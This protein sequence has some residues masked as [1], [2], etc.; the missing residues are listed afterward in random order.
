MEIL[1]L[2]SEVQPWSKTGGLADVA[3]ALP[4]ALA[5]RGH[6]VT[7]VSPLYGGL[8]R[9]APTP[10]SIGRSVE[11][12][13]GDRPYVAEIC[14]AKLG[15][16][17]WLF[18]REDGFFARRALY[19]EGGRDYPD[20]GLRFAF[21]SAAA[22][23]AAAAVGSPPEI[24][25]A[26]DWQTGPAIYL[27]SRARGGG[28]RPG[29]VFTIHNL[30][31]QGL[32]PP[33]VLAELGWPERLFNLHEL[34]FHGSV[35]FL[36]AGAVY[37]DQLSTVSP[38]Y[39]REIRQPEFG[40]GLDGLMRSLDGRLRGIVNGI[41]SSE[42]DP[43]R[44]RQLPAHFHAADLAGKAR[45]KV[46]LQKE[47]GL[48]ALADRPLFTMVGRITPQKGHDL[49]LAVLDG[50]GREL[51]S[52]AQLAILGSGDQGLERALLAKARERPEALAVRVSFDEGLAHRLEAGG[53]F[54]L[55]P[56]RFEP[57][58]LNQ[59]YSL[60]YGALPI[61]RSTGGLADTVQDAAPDLSRG[62]GF[63][64][65]PPTPEALWGAIERALAAY[66]RPAALLALRR[67]GMAQDYSWEASSAR[68]EEMYRETSR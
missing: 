46:A 20:N 65:G 34:E 38:N 56:S 67:A 62:T 52:R 43:R 23:E 9:S 15:Q 66:A 37:A 6:R 44:D 33:N 27:A 30:A 19:G 22:L 29:L 11:V 12:R 50:P 54:F 18:L 57:C 61:V 3:G 17:R 63:A 64:F 31:Y 40:C 13:M 60:R 14:E 8:D 42:W 58:G 39:A 51:L 10:V 45:C 28:A 41:D 21:F 36:K 5:Q 47:L 25:H 7:V 16:V 55:M 68:Y 48:P 2:S 35:S 1:F 26:N 49:L 32:F 53:D 4:Q 24:V 59:L